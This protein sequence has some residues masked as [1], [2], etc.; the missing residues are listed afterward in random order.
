M[1]TKSKIIDI[2]KLHFPDLD[3]VPYDVEIDYKDKSIKI[4]QKKIGKFEEPIFSHF[5]KEKHFKKTENKLLY[6]YLDSKYVKPIL[7]GK[8]RLYN[9]NKYLNK[10]QDPK[11]YSYFIERIGLILPNPEKQLNELKKNIF[12]LSCTDEKNSKGHWESFGNENNLDNACICFKLNVKKNNST[13]DIRNVV[14]ESEL[15]KLFCI[16]ECLFEQFDLKLHIHNF[17]FFAKYFKRSYYSWEDEIRICFDRASYILKKKF[18]ELSDEI[19]EDKHFNVQ[20]DNGYNFIEVETKNDF[21]ELQIDSIQLKTKDI[22]IENLCKEK[23]IR[24]IN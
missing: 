4:E 21:F 17:D 2:F 10:N 11:E 13:I 1:T 20:N 18:S 23:G 6:H 5:I 24:L 19:K 12:I 16:Q 22:E 15:T 8:I 3:I 14:Y 9:L 7:D